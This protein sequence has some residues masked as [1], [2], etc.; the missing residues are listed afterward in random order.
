MGISRHVRLVLPKVVALTLAM[1]LLTLWGSAVAILG[2]G[3]RV[4]SARYE[5]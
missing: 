5:L 4:C 1:P 3:F 2:D